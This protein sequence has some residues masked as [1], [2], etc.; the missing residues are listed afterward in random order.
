MPSFMHGRRH[1]QYKLAH[2]VLMSI[3]Q[4]SRHPPMIQVDVKNETY[5]HAKKKEVQWQAFDDDSDDADGAMEGVEAAK[6]GALINAL[7]IYVGRGRH[8]NG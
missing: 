8:V 5:L 4:S 1:L 2:D 3:G 6:T 7:S